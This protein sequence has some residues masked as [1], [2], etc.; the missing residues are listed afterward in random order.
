VKVQRLI[1]QIN[2][3]I[4]GA[5]EERVAR[6]S[7]SHC[8][9]PAAAPGGSPPARYTTGH[10]V[11][12]AAAPRSNPR[13]RA[14]WPAKKPHQ[15]PRPSPARCAGRRPRVSN[16]LQAP[17]VDRHIRRASALDAGLKCELWRRGATFGG[18]SPASHGT[19]RQARG[20]QLQLSAPII[21]NRDDQLFFPL[22][23]GREFVGAG[24]DWW[25]AAPCS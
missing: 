12:A 14:R 24:W 6:R 10:R 21:P 15:D 7:R 25:A 11:T 8:Q 3:N 2:H 22:R 18:W 1:G 13:Q 17:C 9:W 23:A 19:D 16:P 4:P 20:H 5:V